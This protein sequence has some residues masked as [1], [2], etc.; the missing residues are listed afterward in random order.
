MV[1]LLRIP[2]IVIACFGDCDR[3]AVRRLRARQI[4]L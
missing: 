2:V 1:G 4:V 3:G